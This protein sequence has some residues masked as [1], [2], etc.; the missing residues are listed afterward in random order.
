MVPSIGLEPTTYWLQVSCST[1]WAK[2]AWWK[3]RDS[4]PWHSPCKGDA[5]PAELIFHKWQ[6]VRGSNPCVHGWKPC[7]LTASPTDQNNGA[8]YWDWTNDQLVNSQLLYR[9]AKSALSYLVLEYYNIIFFLSKYF[10]YFFILT[11]YILLLLFKSKI[12]I[13]QNIFKQ[14]NL[15]LYL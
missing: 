4:N 8:D 12:I 15:I 14:N 9:W 11:F 13:A 1:N 10:L 7:V 6:S 3:I 5:L 2:T